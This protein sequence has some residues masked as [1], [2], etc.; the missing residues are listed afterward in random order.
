MKKPFLSF[1]TWYLSVPIH[2]H[3]HVSSGSQLHSCREPFRVLVF[4]CWAVIDATVL[5]LPRNRP[6][7]P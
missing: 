1:G 2:N 5:S 3:S 4:A 7:K 6:R